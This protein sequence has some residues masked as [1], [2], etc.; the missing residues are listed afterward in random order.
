MPAG[1]DHDQR[2]KE[3]AEAT[4]QVAREE[5]ANAVTIRAVAARMGG[6]TTLVTKFIPSRAALLANAFQHMKA[7]WADDQAA[8]LDGMAGAERLHA[9]IRWMFATVGYDAGLRRLWIETVARDPEQAHDHRQEGHDEHEQFA[10]ALRASPCI[11]DLGWLADVLFLAAR[12]YYISSVE[13]PE[14]W[15]SPRAADSV[16]S[17]LEFV[18]QASRKEQH[19]TSAEGR[20]NGDGTAKQRAS[21]PAK[22]TAKR[23]S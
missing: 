20:R 18:E 6:S 23:S 11:A 10:K 1:I 8:A 19:R 5:G 7:Y 17:L 9:L 12:G 16:E 22:R 3:I 4:L 14:R 15:L 2:L 21:R 13:D